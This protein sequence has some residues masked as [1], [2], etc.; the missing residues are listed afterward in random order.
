MGQPST[1]GF[2]LLTLGKYTIH[3]PFQTLVLGNIKI[4]PGHVIN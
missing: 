3:L 1:L 4:T 2:R